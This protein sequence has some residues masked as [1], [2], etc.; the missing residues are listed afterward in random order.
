MSENARISYQD[1]YTD[2]DYKQVMEQLP[3]I[4]KQAEKM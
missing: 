4:I 1:Y 2:E 3:D